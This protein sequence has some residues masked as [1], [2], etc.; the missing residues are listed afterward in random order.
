MNI[1]LIYKYIIIKRRTMTP[2]KPWQ[3]RDNRYVFPFSYV[4][5][6]SLD[7]SRKQHYVKMLSSTIEN[8]GYDDA[9]RLHE[10]IRVIIDSVDW[11]QLRGTRDMPR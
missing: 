7:D 9:S 3:V 4:S 5:G 6:S 8:I 2:P 11:E 1:E 10:Q